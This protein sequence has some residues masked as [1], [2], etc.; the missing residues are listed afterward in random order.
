MWFHGLVSSQGPK[1]CFLGIWSGF[2]LGEVTS[3]LVAS[4]AAFSEISLEDL[5][6]IDGVIGPT[7]KEGN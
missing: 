3:A 4:E 1:K 2:Q 7:V 5:G 6:V